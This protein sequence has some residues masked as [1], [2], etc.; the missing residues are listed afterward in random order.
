MDD[1]EKTTTEAEVQPEVKPEAPAEKTFTQEDVNRIVTERLRS[2][3]ERAEKDRAEAEKLAK[4]NADERLAH[5]REKL[6]EREAAIARRELEAE[7]KSMLSDK[8]LPTDL[9]A[10]LN[11]TD[12]ES[13]KAS[14]EALS[15]TIQQTVESKVAE[16]LKGA[17]PKGGKATTESP[18]DRIISKHTKK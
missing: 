16:R 11:Y 3:R 12:A 8:G 1:N 7:A 6:A 14:V 18:F 15:K 13:V 10:L 17:A 9:H 5:E 4:M 2:E